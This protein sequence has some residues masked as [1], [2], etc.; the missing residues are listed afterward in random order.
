[1]QGVLYMEQNILQSVGGRIR[2]I[3]KSKGLSQEELGEKANFHYSYIGRIERGE[4]NISLVNLGKI[5]D[6]L[7]VGVHQFFSY[8]HELEKLTEKD[9]EMKEILVLL[10]RQ[11]QEDIRKAKNILKEFFK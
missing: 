5:A 9:E 6:A 2:E 8:A 7:G 11:D 10:Q 4:K 3:R 1:M